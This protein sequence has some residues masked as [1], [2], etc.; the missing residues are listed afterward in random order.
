MCPLIYG[1]SA[2]IYKHLVGEFFIRPLI[3]M[4]ISTNIHRPSVCDSLELYISL[5]NKSIE[6]IT[7]Y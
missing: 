5:V 3:V 6:L 2:L 4:S 7:L 1:C